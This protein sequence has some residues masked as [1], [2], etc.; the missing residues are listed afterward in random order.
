MSQQYISATRE[1]GLAKVGLVRSNISLTKQH[2]C[3]CIILTAC[4]G[5]DLGSGAV[6]HQ[7][8]LAWTDIVPVVEV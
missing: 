3:F 1:A 5:L 6:T 8:S 7:P 4:G 2:G